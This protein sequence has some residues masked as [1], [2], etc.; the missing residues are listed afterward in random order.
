[1]KIGISSSLVMLD[2]SNGGVLAAQKDGFS[3]GLL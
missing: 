1:M 3:G 2:T